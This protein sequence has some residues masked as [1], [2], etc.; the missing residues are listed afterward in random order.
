[1][2]F[3]IIED[4]YRLILKCKLFFLMKEEKLRVRFLLLLSEWIKVVFE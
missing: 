4:V 2:V 1:M 3:C